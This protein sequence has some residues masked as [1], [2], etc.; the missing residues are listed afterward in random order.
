MKKLLFTCFCLSSFAFISS[1]YAQALGSEIIYQAAQTEDSTA[2]KNKVIANFKAEQSSEIA[3]D[4]LA[5][6]AV[7]YMTFETESAKDIALYNELIP[8]IEQAIK[9]NKSV[10]RFYLHKLDMANFAN[11][12]K[13]VAQTLEQIIA[14]SKETD[15]AW[16]IDTGFD[17]YTDAEHVFS[18]LE[19]RF[20]SFFENVIAEKNSILVDGVLTSLK[21]QANNFYMPN[22]IL[23]QYYILT[24]QTNELEKYA[25]NAIKLNNQYA[26]TYILAL[27][28]AK[29][30]QQKAMSK[31]YYDLAQQHIKD[32]YDLKLIKSY[33]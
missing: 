14:I 26:R 30:N 22:L 20:V 12:H 7:S 10:L 4:E 5:H 32:D 2:V 1:I 29:K 19:T 9:E 23:M 13:A 17:V 8:Y 31:K 15:Y 33:K 24:N 28:Y 25:D 3:I 18:D 21:V 16:N 6:Y 27:D 11:Q